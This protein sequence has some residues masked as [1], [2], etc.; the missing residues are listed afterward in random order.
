MNIHLNLTP[1]K[2]EDY[3]NPTPE[4]GEEGEG[5]GEQT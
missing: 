3:L 5:E 4:S 1:R 2:E